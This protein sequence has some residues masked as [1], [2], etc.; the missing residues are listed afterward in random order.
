MTD[1]DFLLWM[2]KRLINVYG[3]P[4]GTDFVTRLAEIAESMTNAKKPVIVL[5]ITAAKFK[6]ATGNDPMHD[7]LERVNC[8]MRGPNH[9]SCGWCT[10]CDAPRFQCGGLH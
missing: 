6:E 3:E 5:N 8:S 1:K 2:S 9:D 7:D 10:T 4:R